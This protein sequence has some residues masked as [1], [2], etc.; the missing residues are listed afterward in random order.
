MQLYAGAWTLPPKPAPDDPD[1][2][3]TLYPPISRSSRSIA[4]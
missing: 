2:I 3:V 1:A 4:G